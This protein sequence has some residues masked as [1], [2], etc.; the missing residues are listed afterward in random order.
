MTRCKPHP[1]L[2]LENRPDDVTSTRQTSKFFGFFF[3]SF[4][5]LSLSLSLPAPSLLASHREGQRGRKGGGREGGREPGCHFPNFIPLFLTL[6]ASTAVVFFIGSVSGRRLC[7][8]CVPSRMPSHPHPPHP[9][10]P[11]S[12][13]HFHPDTHACRLMTKNERGRKNEGQ[14]LRR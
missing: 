14:T 5:H 1:D 10:P 6:S 13:F 3:L 12:H 8:S 7:L 11:D 4:F 2:K 9:R